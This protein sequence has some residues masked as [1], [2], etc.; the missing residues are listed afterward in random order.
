MNEI[1]Y[2]QI[3]R[4]NSCG[5]KLNGNSW[6]I[7]QSEIC[8]ECHQNKRKHILYLCEKCGRKMFNPILR[9]KRGKHNI[10]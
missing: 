3:L 4:C 7:E 1:N 9:E 8:Q 2:M 6:T 10:W 5:K